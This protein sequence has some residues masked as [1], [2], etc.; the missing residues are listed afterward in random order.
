VP[1]LGGELAGRY[2]LPAAPGQRRLWFL[3]QL[4]PGAGSAYRIDTAARLAGPL[5]PAALQAALDGVV[6]RHETLRTAFVAVDGEPVQVV[7]PTPAVPLRQVDLAGA[8]DVAAAAAELVR[9]A[10]A[11]PFDLAVA[12]LLRVTVGRLGPEDHL[13][14]LCLHHVVGDRWSVQV[15]LREL[16]T[17]YAAARAGTRPELPALPVQYGDWAAAQLA[18]LA[19]PEAAAEVEHWRDRLAGAPVLELPTDRPRPAVRRSA[20]AL[21]WYDL[22]ADLL[23][24]VDAAAGQLG[25]TPFMLALAAFDVL[26]ARYCGQPDVVVGTPVAGRDRPEV[27]PLIGFFV[28]TSVLRTDVSGDPTVGELVARVRETCLDAYAHARVPFERLVEELRPSRDLGRTPLFPVLFAL[29]NTPAAAREMAGLEVTPVDVD[30]G[31]SQFDLSVMVV[32]GAGGGR[33]RVEYDTDL[34]D[35]DTVDR[36][37]AHYRML[38]AEFAGSS[39]R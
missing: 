28:G 1:Q 6:A 19:G 18:W 13:L 2:V 15:L 21:R 9:S 14:H 20:G 12:P 17:A 24:A 38:L 22:P 4:D 31:T 26:L 7:A 30:P 34:F 25:A 35:A 39:I 29:Q 27:E 5:D 8:A 16:V 33:L 23:S 36:M 11:E 10:A 3:T 32:P 37:A